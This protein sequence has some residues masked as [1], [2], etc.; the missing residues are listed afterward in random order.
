M[1]LNDSQRPCGLLHKWPGNK[2]HTSIDSNDG[3][4]GAL[5]GEGNSAW[6]VASQ[7]R[8][9]TRHVVCLMTLNGPGWNGKAIL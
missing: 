4:E 7:H 6:E 9:N 8:Q 2:F 1:H 3:L 5:S